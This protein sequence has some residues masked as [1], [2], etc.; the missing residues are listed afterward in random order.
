MHDRLT[1]EQTRPQDYEL[2]VDIILTC[3]IL[4]TLGRK[5]TNTT[6]LFSVNAYNPVE[7]MPF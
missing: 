1:F 2:G 4:I 5:K 6:P 7:E 3:K